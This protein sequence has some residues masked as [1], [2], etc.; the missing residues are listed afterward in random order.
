VAEPNKSSELPDWIKNHLSRYLATDGADGYLWDASVGGGKGLVPTLLL[1]SRL[2][3]GRVQ[4]RRAGASCLVLESG[5][6]PRSA[7]Q[8]R[9][10]HRA[11]THLSCRGARG[12]V[13]EDGR[14]IWTL[15]AVPDQDRP[16]N[17]F[18][19]L[20]ADLSVGQRY[21]K[22]RICISAVA[23]L[24]LGGAPWQRTGREAVGK[25]EVG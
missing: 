23:S 5:G 8:G 16:A 24:F 14:N 22:R 10:V 3:G 25:P 2:R 11:C 18:R 13:G 17:S 15:R 7:G 9:Q 1:G 20:E 21:A 19:C 6:K 12:T 4:G